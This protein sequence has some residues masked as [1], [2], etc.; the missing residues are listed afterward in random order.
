M[1]PV[2]VLAN[3]TRHLPGWHSSVPRR[4]RRPEFVGIQ[5]HRP[6]ELKVE[7][8]TGDFL[9]AP[10]PE[11]VG[12]QTYDVA[13]NCAE[14]TSAEMGKQG[15]EKRSQCR[16]SG[17]VGR[18]AEVYSNEP[19]TDIERIKPTKGLPATMADVLLCF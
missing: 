5:H 2:I 3:H 13:G 8:R 12:S 16:Y 6:T 4:R 9:S 17:K 1:I 19:G 18:L 7:I 15:A 14:A 11:V 10:G